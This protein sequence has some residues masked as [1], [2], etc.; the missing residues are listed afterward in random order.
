MGTHGDPARRIWRLFNVGI[1]G[2]AVLLAAGL[3]GLMALNGQRFPPTAPCSPAPFHLSSTTV[4]PGDTLTVEAPDTECH[5]HYGQNA[6]V[7]VQ[8][9]GAGAASRVRMLA[10]MNDDGGFSAV[11]NVPASAAPGE[12]TVSAA[13][14]GIDTCFDS[15]HVQGSA[16]S[17]SG[18]LG[19]AALSVT[20][21]PL[22]QDPRASPSGR[23]TR[24]A[25]G[26]PLASCALPQT[27]LTVVAR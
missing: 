9:L 4:H 1:L 20:T 14:Q 17:G 11:L 27:P 16:R 6:Q 18:G 7:E 19:A 21:G 13:P 22:P 10:P 2:L 15:I 24:D 3:F 23:G 25:A 5:P 12:Y 8:L 26:V